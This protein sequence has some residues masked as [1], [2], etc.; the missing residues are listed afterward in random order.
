MLESLFWFI[1]FPFFLAFI[2]GFMSYGIGEI[3]NSANKKT[4][5]DANP[6]SS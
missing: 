1:T 5:K 3:A 4:E 2:I 6:V